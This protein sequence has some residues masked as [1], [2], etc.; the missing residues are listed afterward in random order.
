MAVG[1]ACV[2]VLGTVVLLFV[3]QPEDLGVELPSPVERVFVQPTFDELPFD[4]RGLENRNVQEQLIGSWREANGTTY[5]F[6]PDGS[7]DTE[8]EGQKVT[9]QYQWQDETTLLISDEPVLVEMPDPDTLVL[10]NVASGDVF[11]LTRR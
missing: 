9:L 6:Y 3:V 8:I 1:L 11:Q 7:F 10:T 2:V 5:Y 4:N